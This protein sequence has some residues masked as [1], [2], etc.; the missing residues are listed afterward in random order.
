[1]FRNLA[2][3]T[4]QR[5]REK[6]LEKTLKNI[7]KGSRI[8]DAGAGELQYKKFC[9]HLNYVSQD[10]CKYDGMGDGSGLQTSSW[11]NS[12]ADIKCDIITIPEPNGSFDAIMC[13][14]VFEHLPDPIAALKEFNRLLSQGGYLILTAPYASLTHFAPFHFY[15]GFSRYFYQKWLNELGFNIVEIVPNGNYFEFLR[16]EIL[17]LNYMAKEYATKAGSLRLVEYFVIWMILRTL[18][19]F[20]KNDNGSD[21]VLCYGYHVLATKR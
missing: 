6:W 2:G 10:F 20:S 19:R 1:M 8:L 12:K 11:N 5:D 18:K 16:Q 14:E 17:R 3:T 9:T 13:I 21:E 7:R 4:N 15:S